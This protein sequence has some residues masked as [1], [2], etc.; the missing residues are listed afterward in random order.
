[1]ILEAPDCDFN[2]SS[3]F[4][5]AYCQMKMGWGPKESGNGSKLGLKLSFKSSRNWLKGAKMSQKLT[6]TELQMN[7]IW[8]QNGFKMKKGLFYRNSTSSGLK[9]N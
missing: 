3:F 5:W 7:S 9:L 1:M 2:L 8:T 4:E 6:L